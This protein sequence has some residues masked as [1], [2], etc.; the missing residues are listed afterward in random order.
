IWV[1]R[2]NVSGFAR[3]EWLMA[4]VIWLTFGGL[5][6]GRTAR[7]WRGRRAALLTIAGFTVSLAVLAIYLARRALGG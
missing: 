3:P 4:V 5:I 7:G 6:A 2:R 1:A